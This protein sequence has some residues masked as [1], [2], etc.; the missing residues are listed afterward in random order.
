MNCI[1]FFCV[2]IFIVSLGEM[3]K[4]LYAKY[5]PLFCWREE[6]NKKIVITVNISLI[7]IFFG[8]YYFLLLPGLKVG[9]CPEG[10]RVESM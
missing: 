8:H 1:F 9:I 6:V 7:I 4:C 3:Q 5:N 10:E 2:H